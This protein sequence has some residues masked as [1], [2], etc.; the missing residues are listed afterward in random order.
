MGESWDEMKIMFEIIKR[1]GVKYNAFPDCNTMEETYDVRLKG[2]GMTFEDFKKKHII[3]IPMEYK[4]YEKSGFRTPTGKVEL[5]SQ[6][7]KDLGYDPLP[8]YVEP[9]Q[10]HLSTPAL[11][12][13]YPYMLITNGLK[14]GYMHSMGRN[15]PWLRELV[16]D[17][18]VEIHPATAKE[19]GIEDG[20]WVW[21]EAARGPS[22]RVKG[23]AKLTR[24]V[25]PKMIQYMAH[26]WLP[27][28]A[29]LEYGQ[30]DV[31]INMI[32][33]NDPIDPIS[34]TPPLTGLLCKVYKAERD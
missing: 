7:F 3:E 26:W 16:P 32:L 14:I 13:E 22:G 17:P 29:G 33:S 15:I 11:A 23:I 10:S 25:H 30:S 24:G 12:E 6:T 4:K 19:L 9:H 5:Y 20:D 27:E 18:E 2:L 28:K 34:G 1:M 31:N 8:H 21:A